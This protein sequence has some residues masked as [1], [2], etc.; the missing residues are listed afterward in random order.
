MQRRM[1]EPAWAERHWADVYADTLDKDRIGQDPGP[2]K[3]DEDGRMPEPRQRQ[4]VVRPLAPVRFE[5]RALRLLMTQE[6]LTEW[7]ID[8]LFLDAD[9]RA[10]HTLLELADAVECVFAFFGNGLHDFKK[11][12]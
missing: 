12:T 9:D 7:E 4:P 11:R 1:Y 3:I 8:E 2:I 5:L 10:R 6:I